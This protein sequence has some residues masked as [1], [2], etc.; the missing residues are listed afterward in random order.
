MGIQEELEKYNII[1]DP[2]KDQFLLKD[3]KMVDEIVRFADLSKDDIVLEIGAGTGVLTKELAKR[4]G[5]VI[6][7]EIDRKFRPFLEKF[8]S[9]K[10]TA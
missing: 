4:A 7:F 8:P 10:S 3:E 2:L 1:P 9:K 5:K 6:A